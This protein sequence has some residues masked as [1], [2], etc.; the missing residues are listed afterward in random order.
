[1]HIVLRYDRLNTEITFFFVFFFSLNFD[2]DILSTLSFYLV[3]KKWR[4]TLCHRNEMGYALRN[5]FEAVGI[6]ICNSS[7]KFETTIH[8]FK[9]SRWLFLQSGDLQ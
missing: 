2:I 4:S 3:M 5:T 6:I 7:K 1:M 9:L 8:T